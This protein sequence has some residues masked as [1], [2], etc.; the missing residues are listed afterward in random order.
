MKHSSCLLAFLIGCLTITSHAAITGVVETGLGADPVAIVG[1]A[2]EGAALVYSDRAHVHMAA[3]FDATTFLPNVTG[4]TAGVLPSY[5]VGSPYVRFANAARENVGYSAVVTS[6]VPAVFYLLVDNRLNGPAGLGNKTNT[7]DP[8]LGGGLQ[9]VIDGGWVRVNT[10]ISPNGQGDFT[11]IDE[12]PVDGILNQFFSVYKFP[13]VAGSVTVKN[14][15]FNGNNNVVLIAGPAPVTGDPITS[16]IAQPSP[17]APGDMASLAWVIH[18]ATVTASVDQGV[19]NVLP[20][21]TAG[22][23]TVNVTPAVDTTY[24]MSTTG[25]AG[26]GSATATIQVRPL[27]FLQASSLFAPSGSPVTLSWRIRTDAVATLTG[28][29]SV[30][31]L[32]LPDGTGSV[33]VNPTATTT[34]TLSSMAG[35][36]T[37]EASV[38]VVIQPGGTLFSIIDIGSTDGRAE[39]GA[40]SGLEIGAG[41]N[42]TN[43]T[44]LAEQALTSDTGVPFTIAMDNLNPDGIPTGGLDWRDRG[45]G[46][47]IPLLL[48]AEDHVKNN[49]G[50]I[51]VTLGGLPAGTYGVTS[52]H[53]DMGNSQCADI[54]VRVAD[55]L[56]AVATDTG[57]VGNASFPGH[58]LNTG[59]PRPAASLPRSW[60]N[61]RRG[62][63]LL[64]MGSTRCRSGSTAQLTWWTR[65]RRWPVCGSRAIH[66]RIPSVPLPD[67]PPAIPIGGT[68]TLSWLIAANAS[69]A[70]I[71][72]GVGDVFPLTAAG[73]GNTTVM[74]AVDTTYQLSVNSPAGPET[75]TVKVEVK[76]LEFLRGSILVVAPGTPVTLSWR[77]RP[78]AAASIPG[79]GS[80]AAFTGVDGTGNAVVSP[81]ADTTYTIS[82]TG[83][84]RTETASITIQMRAPGTQFAIID[85]GGTDGRPEPGAVSGAEVGAGPNNT[86]GAN[87]TDFAL[88]SDTGAAFTLSLD[89][90]NPEGVP[91]GG[92]DWRDRGD[93]PANAFAFL[94]EDHVK[95]NLGMIHVTLGNLPAGAY[96][97]SSFHLDATV[98]QCAA[99]RILVSDALRTASDTGILGNGSWPGHPLNTGAPGVAGL[100]YATVNQHAARFQIFSDGINPVSIWFDGTADLVDP[101]VPLAGL[102]LIQSPARTYIPLAIL[103]H[104]AIA[105]TTALS[106]TTDAGSTYTVQASHDLISW[107]T[108]TTTLTGAAQATPFSE[109]GI[110]PGTPKRFYRAYRN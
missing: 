23:G 53:Y 13:T 45:D 106:L 72:Q 101:E 9:W 31:P 6:D 24:T 1:T 33:V 107:A 100:T 12:N 58:P 11:G 87:L 76:L 92:L 99:I 44:N 15:G 20:A 81:T 105:G 84:G 90:L 108:L 32:T 80:L 93:G 78:D 5:L 51:H 86:N 57:A 61:A 3:Q 83:S 94:A 74:P 55:A 43:L 49:L 73:I 96:D 88:T 37:E 18:P 2:F 63:R 22:I 75:A 103:S 28:T 36:R 54:R 95:N 10:G 98:S 35:G 4:A 82:S 104:D 41:I 71:D 47:A 7:T 64:R 65:R 29:G 79:I 85:L 91:I 42:N 26:P 17:L 16:F 48:L 25:P 67:R 27:A 50:M 89:N 19:G 68:A 52:Y 77:V 110:T 97:V 38:T 34:Y 60:I 14:T 109:N 21:T 30:A 56:R 39:P 62:S 8:I 102:W 40:S 69:T 70:V 46:A 66:R 59:V